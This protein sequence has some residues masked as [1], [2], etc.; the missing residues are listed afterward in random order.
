MIKKQV[1]I[2]RTADITKKIQSLQFSNDPKS[3]RTLKKEMDYPSKG[4]SY[5]DLKTIA[6]AD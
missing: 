4:S 5:A 6:K 3:K 2:H 1:K